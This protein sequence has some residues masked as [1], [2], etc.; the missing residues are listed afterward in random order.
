MLPGMGPWHSILSKGYLC[1]IA[2]QIIVREDSMAL[3]FPGALALVF[4]CA[5]SAGGCSS[6]D[7]TAQDG[8]SVAVNFGDMHRCSRISP[9]IT[10]YNAPRETQYFEVRLTP[11]D[12]PSQYLGGGRWKCA[13]RN[14][15][16]ADVI[17]EGTLVNS[18]RGPCPSAGSGSHVFRY[19]VSAMSS[20]SSTPLAVSSYTVDLDD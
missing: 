6:A 12:N 7:S 13:G 8:M 18:Y 4:I 1:D 5:L 15:D 2:Q 20:S 11:E 3:R 9:E 16:N 17:P 10:I 14:E 19:T